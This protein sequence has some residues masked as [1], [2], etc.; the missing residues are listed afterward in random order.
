MWLIN[1]A[2]L[3]S[4]NNFLW[5]SKIGGIMIFLDPTNDLVFKKLFG[6]TAHKN[7]LMSFLNS[8]LERTGEDQIADVVF[9][10][11]HNIPEPIQAKHT[12]VDVR[13]TDQKG[14]NYIVEMQVIKQKDYAERCQYYSALALGR[15]LQQKDEYKKLL[16]VI[17]VAIL[18][19]DLFKSPNYTSHHLILDKAT[20]EHGLRHL[21]FHFIEL[22]KFNKALEAV[23]SIS[24]KWIYLLK[25]ADTM[26]TVPAAFKEP[27]VKEA[28]EI[29]EQ[30][31]W[32]VKELE[33]YD[34]YLDAIRSQKS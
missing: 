11:P 19:F 26:K 12:I 16:P 2:I 32:S 4:Y 17:F 29:L 21:E 34:R 18:C 1:F 28:F 33:A 5:M 14:F 22:N 23:K 20:G 9:N 10:D 7:I 25:N 24:D 27:A 15:Q 31:N 6:N 30:G 13:C 3:F 8:I